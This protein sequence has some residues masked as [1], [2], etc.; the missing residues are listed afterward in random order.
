MRIHLVINPGQLN[1]YK[2]S[3]EV[4]DNL[5]QATRCKHCGEAISYVGENDHSI[6]GKWIHM[7]GRKNVGCDKSFFAEPI[8]D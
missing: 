6:I 1:E 4:P 3:L 2:H 8:D 7:E 5:T